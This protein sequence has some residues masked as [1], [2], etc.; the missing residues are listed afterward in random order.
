MICS[1]V[2]DFKSHAVGYIVRLGWSL[3]HSAPDGLNPNG[4]LKA[5][6]TLKTTRKQDTKALAFILQQGLS[7]WSNKEV[8]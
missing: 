4:L 6:I 1:E 2:Q 5:A 7:D 3:S 8:Q